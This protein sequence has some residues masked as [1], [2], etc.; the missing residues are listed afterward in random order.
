MNLFDL[1][2]LITDSPREVSKLLSENCVY[3]RNFKI[4]E[5]MHPRTNKHIH[6]HSQA[7]YW[8]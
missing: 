6:H 7:N 4:Y 2:I 1:Q 5:R 8:T 3:L